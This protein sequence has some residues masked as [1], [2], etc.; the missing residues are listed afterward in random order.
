ML[1]CSWCFLA[2]PFREA[3]RLRRRPSAGDKTSAWLRAI[4]SE[5]AEVLLTRTRP[6]CGSRFPAS[7][8]GL[9]ALRPLLWCALPSAPGAVLG[10]ERPAYP[11]RLWRE[12]SDRNGPGRRG[13]AAPPGVFAGPLRGAFQA[14]ARSLPRVLGPASS[15]GLA[16][17]FDLVVALGFAVAVGFEQRS[18]SRHS[19]VRWYT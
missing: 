7:R 16:F 9:S 15:P 18:G 14:S 19:V 1:V 3:E 5:Q 6:F 4:P 2:R 11:D 13:A 12:R 10:A 8:A 17:A